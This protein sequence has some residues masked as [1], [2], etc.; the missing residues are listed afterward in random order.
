M[1]KMSENSI[2]F[3]VTDPPYA[4]INK[5]GKGGF[6]GKSW[7]SCIP[8]IPFWQEALRICKPGSMLAAFGGTR[9]FHRLTCAI[10]DAGWEIRDVMCYL[11]GSGFPKSH[12]NFGFSGYGT[13]LKPSWEPIIICMKPLDGTYAKNAEKWGVGGINIDDSRIPTIPRQTHSDGNHTGNNKIYGKIGEGYQGL[14]ANARWPANLIL[15]EESAEILD[16][17]CEKNNMRCMKASAPSTQGNNSN[18]GSFGPIGRGKPCDFNDSGGASR[19]FYCAKAS[20]RERNAGLNREKNLHPTVKPLSL[21]R[22]LIKLL[23]PPGNPICLDPFMGSGSTGV[24]CKELGINFI[25]IE[26]EADYCEI[27]K[28]RIVHA[29]DPDPDLFTSRE[30]SKSG[31]YQD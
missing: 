25:G 15:D 10:E 19:F 21:M 13:A 12:N 14:G 11:Y 26:K 8:G 4:L 5:S 29:K 23:A 16:Q 1:S 6:M 9:T 17:Q 3:I 20:S 31:L 22:Y 28:R 30:H 24:A 27:A 18:S 7:D 2:D